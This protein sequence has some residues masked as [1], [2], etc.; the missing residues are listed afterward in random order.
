MAL[1]KVTIEVAVGN[2]ESADMGLPP[3]IRYCPVTFDP[4]YLMYYIDYGE[5]IGFMVGGTPFNCKKT[6]ENIKKFE[7][8]FELKFSK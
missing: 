8:A 7:E 6:E 5:S 3:V 1:N 4:N 2:K